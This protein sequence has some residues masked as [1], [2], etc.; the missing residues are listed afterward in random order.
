MIDHVSI[1]VRDLARAGSFYDAVLDTLGLTRLVTRER[2]YGYG[3]AY[4]EFWLNLRPGMTGD[5]NGMHVCLRAPNVEAVDA[6][7]AAALA[8][9]AAPDGA[10]GLRPQYHEA[11]YAAYIRDA[12]GNRIE[13]MALLRDPK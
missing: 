13:A 4:G 3:K 11:Y 5:D 7:Y 12:D 6:F 2:T 8:S 1:G 9:G 10:P